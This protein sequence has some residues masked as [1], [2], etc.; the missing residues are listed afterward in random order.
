M[1]KNVKARAL[2]FWNAFSSAAQLLV[3]RCCIDLRCG[4]FPPVI[5]SS[6]S[7]ESLFGGG[8]VERGV[9]VG[10]GVSFGVLL[11]EVF[12]FAFFDGL[13]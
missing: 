6:G 12:V 13:S 11:T 1:I 3:G 5:T 7:S 9:V 4:Y 10:S 2:D 8:W